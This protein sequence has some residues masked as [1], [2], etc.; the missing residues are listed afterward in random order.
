M[1]FGVRLGFFWGGSHWLFTDQNPVLD[2]F[3]QTQ[4]DQKWQ[5]IF[6][7][8]FYFSRTL[9]NTVFSDTSAWS[10]DIFAHPL[11][12]HLCV[13]GLPWEIFPCLP[14]WAASAQPLPT[15]SEQCWGFSSAAGLDFMLCLRREQ[16]S[17]LTRKESEFRLSSLRAFPLDRQIN[18]EL[19]IN[20]PCPLISPNSRAVLC[21]G[22][23]FSSHKSPCAFSTG[24]RE[25]F[26]L[27]TTVFSFD[28]CYEI[29][30]FQK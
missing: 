30:H 12:S 25:T 2:L 17:D 23:H 21:E 16:D 27:A 11:C 28:C 8:P 6:G 10:V 13:P 4:S 19:F 14:S 29:Q 7:N 1:A 24:S 3:R 5:I 26:I 18:C 22:E 9:E 15:W 20:L